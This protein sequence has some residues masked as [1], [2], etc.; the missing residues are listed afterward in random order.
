MKLYQDSTKYKPL[1]F[2]ETFLT[3]ECL[4]KYES[5][6][7]DYSINPSQVSSKIGGYIEYSVSEYIEGDN[8]LRKVYFKDQLNTLLT[9]NVILTCKLL[10][11]RESEIQ[12]Q[13]S[14]AD[15]FINKQLNVLVKI[16][17][18]VNSIPNH[19]II[20]LKHLKTIGLCLNK[21]LVNTNFPIKRPAK[22]LST[23]SYFGTKVSGKVLGSLY[24]ASVT[25]N[26]IDSDIVTKDEF[27][28]VFISPNPKEENRKI[29]F[30][31]DNRSIMF[32]LNAIEPLFSNLSASRISASQA[33]YNKSMKLLNQNDINKANHYLRHNNIGKY[34]EI[35]EAVKPFLSKI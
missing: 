7:Y 21:L 14:K 33:F 10:E 20:I 4:H 24:Y 12:Y 1:Q 6:F 26:I 8:P 28:D 34:S 2:F 5:S 11:E 30:N 15:L 25:L 31:R 18:E 29:I 16:K 19:K 32:Y 3:K 17:K 22:Q 13:N 23:S 27:L 35:T 9:N